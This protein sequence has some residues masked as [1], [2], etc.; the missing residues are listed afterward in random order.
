[1]ERATGSRWRSPPL[2]QPTG[3]DGIPTKRE[4][5]LASF[6]PRPE[7]PLGY[8]PYRMPDPLLPGGPEAAR[9]DDIFII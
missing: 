1:L 3:I 9:R 6:Q 8:L 4:V 2:H 5:S 7:S